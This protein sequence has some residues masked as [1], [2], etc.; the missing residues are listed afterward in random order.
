MKVSGSYLCGRLR[1]FER[2]TISSLLGHWIKWQ[3]PDRERTDQAAN[4]ED[5][6]ISFVYFLFFL[7]SQ[8]LLY[9]VTGK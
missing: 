7:H 9:D 2:Q 8:K 5:G 1:I 4:S 6:L 3:R